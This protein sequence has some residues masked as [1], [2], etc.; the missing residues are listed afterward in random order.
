MSLPECRA[1]G[2]CG[3][4]GRPHLCSFTVP[5]R[6]LQG[7]VGRPHEMELNLTSGRAHFNPWPTRIS[8][9]DAKGHLGSS[10]HRPR[11]EELL[12]KLGY[13]FTVS[14]KFHS[15]YSCYKNGTKVP[16]FERF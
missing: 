8:I 16:E 10:W 3:T 1:Q 14:S 7:N 6:G 2:V 12:T 11:E 9:G 13:C 4:V 5:I 15:D